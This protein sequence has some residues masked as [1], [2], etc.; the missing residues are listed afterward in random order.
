MGGILIVILDIN[1]HTHTHAY[2]K[3]MWH[4]MFVFLLDYVLVNY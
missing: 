3:H 2:R 1:T 4:M